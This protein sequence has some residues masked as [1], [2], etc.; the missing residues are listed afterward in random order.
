MSPPGSPPAPARN[1]PSGAK[2]G[3]GAEVAE[4]CVSLLDASSAW[5]GGVHDFGAVTGD[6]SPPT[7]TCPSLSPL[8]NIPR[9]ITAVLTWS[10][11]IGK[12]F[13]H[14]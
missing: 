7:S 9:A 2:S 6:A 3:S 8:C 1:G 14:F 5:D 10:S 4:M 12:V 13:S 11:D